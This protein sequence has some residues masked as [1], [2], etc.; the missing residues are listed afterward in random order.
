MS[1]NLGF[2][3]A[4]IFIV[5]IFP[6][7][8][9]PCTSFVIDEGKGPVFG[10]N[11]DYHIGYGMAIVNKRGVEKTAVSFAQPARWVSKYG[12]VTFNAYGREMPMGG[13]N[14]AGLVVE[15]M[16]LDKTQYPPEDSTETRPTVN[17]LQWIQYQL[18]TAGTVKEVIESDEQIR[19][20][21]PAA[22]I[23]FLICDGG[24]DCAVV[25]FL[26]GAMI[27]H[28][29]ADL[30][31]RVLTNS[32]YDSSVEFLDRFDGNRE[33]QDY[34]AGGRTLGRF[35]TASGMVDSY[36]P[37]SHDAAIDRSF[38][39]LEKVSFQEFTRWSIVYDIANG[40]IY[41]RT[42]TNAERRTLDLSR[43]DFACGTPVM[44]HDLDAQAA[45][46]ITGAMETYSFETNRD[47]IMKA[48]GETEFLKDTPVQV[49]EMLARYP[50][51]L[52]CSQ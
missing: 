42:K 24:G 1:R 39:I 46:D 18:D 10:R 51:T 40:L 41:F 29:G 6:G 11:L 12:S 13:M 50:D 34:L 36:E 49:L 30:P 8:A 33:A 47:L 28:R 35:V 20:Y 2:W 15:N 32:T 7:V 5:L 22:T 23:H 17:S 21:D 14:E 37:E 38:E 27:V 31:V 48:F 9:L 16:W 3:S 45:G 25:E 52:P 26:D 44:V 4:V 19:I 43:L